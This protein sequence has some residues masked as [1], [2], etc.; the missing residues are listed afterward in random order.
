MR[1]STTSQRSGTSR[2]PVAAYV[3][4]LSTFVMGTSEFIVMGLLPTVARSFSVSLPA[5]GWLITAYALG[6][7]VGGPIVALSTTRIP[8]KRLI[9]ILMTT[10]IIGNALCALAPTYASMMAA[11]IVTAIGQG[12]FFGIGAVLAARLVPEHRRA[13]AIATMFGGLT[14]A[15]VLGVPA[16]TAIGHWAGWRMPFWTIAALGIVALIGLLAALPNQHDEEPVDLRGEIRALANARIWGALA[17]TVLFTTATFPLFTYIAPILGLT[18]ASSHDLTLSL[19][20]VGVGLTIGNHLGGRLADW[21]VIRALTGIAAAMALVSLSLRWTSTN[22]VSANLNWFGW[23]VAT[24]AAIPAL[25]F[26]IMRFGHQAPNLVS[27]LNI[28]AFNVGIALGARVGGVALGAGYALLDLPV[29]ASTLSIIAMLAVVLT[30][31][32]EAQTCTERAEDKG[33]RYR[34]D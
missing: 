24:F 5:A 1:Q 25:Q 22:L 16:G 10:F 21:D 15:N 30:A 8:R 29:A 11:R 6:I 3:L 32:L 2:L 9:T 14:L 31:R 23:G 4:T 13:S 19:L 20:L 28:G 34:P 7:A 27:T 33:H 18:S 12:A 26:H 17:T